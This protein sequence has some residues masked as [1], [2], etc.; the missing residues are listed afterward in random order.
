MRGSSRRSRRGSPA[1]PDTALAS[2][3]DLA[4][5]LGRAEAVHGE[6]EKRTEQRDE[7]WL[8]DGRHRPKAVFE[9]RLHGAKLPP[10]LCG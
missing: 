3:A 9:G 1:E 7:S 8:D 5:A 4:S 6:H 10:P 2:T